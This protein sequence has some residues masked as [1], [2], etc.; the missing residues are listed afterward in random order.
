MHINKLNILMIYRI[1][2]MNVPVVLLVYMAQYVMVLRRARSIT[3]GIGRVGP[4][5]PIPRVMGFGCLKTIKYK[6]HIKA[7]TLVILCI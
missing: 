5:L 6:L 4:P 7:G 1:I 2:T 3:R